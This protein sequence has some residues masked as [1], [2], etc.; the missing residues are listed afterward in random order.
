[1]SETKLGNENL[2]LNERYLKLTQ[3]EIADKRL[4]HQLFEIDR[5]KAKAK[6]QA[7]VKKIR[8]SFWDIEDIKLDMKLD[9]KSKKYR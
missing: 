8:E 7:S 1:M 6:A 5:A 3:E 9:M 4:D 2:L